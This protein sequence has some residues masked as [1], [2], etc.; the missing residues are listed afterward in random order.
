MRS[1]DVIAVDTSAVLAIIQGEPE[2]NEFINIIKNADR[3]VISAVSVLEAGMV[4]RGRRGAVGFDQ[5]T[6]IID[7]MA[8]EI[9]P[10]NH[11]LA[12]GALDAFNRYGKGISPIAK[13]NLGDC[14]S[15][16]LAKSMNAPLLFKGNDFSATDIVSA[17]V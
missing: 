13:L 16:A 3:V 4:L 9:V 5:L 2:G 8:I 11:L 7:G 1:A 17:R 6:G 14:A 12:A 10:F 15:Y